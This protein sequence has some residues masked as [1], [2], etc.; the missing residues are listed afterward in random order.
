VPAAAVLGWPLE[1]TLSPRLHQAAYR[2]AGLHDWS[3]RALPTRP[4]E[5]AGTL[6]RVRSGAL[7]GVNLTTPHKRAAVGL[8]DELRPPAGELGAVNTIWRAGGPGAPP[9]A[10]RCVL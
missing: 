1:H 4:E 6:D 7:A 2:A 10:R 8:L 5:L 9:P 3:Y